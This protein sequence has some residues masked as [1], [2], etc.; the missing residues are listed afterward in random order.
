MVSPVTILSGGGAVTL[1]LTVMGTPEKL[2]SSG[3]EMLAGVR[4]AFPSSVALEVSILS[5]VPVTS[6]FVLSTVT[7]IF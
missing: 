5:R 2:Y 4:T 7:V 1:Y 6:N 3:L